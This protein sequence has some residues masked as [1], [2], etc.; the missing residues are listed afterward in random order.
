MH[1]YMHT[2]HKHTYTHAY[3][4]AYIR[5]KRAIHIGRRR[6][7]PHGLRFRLDGRFPIVDGIFRASRQASHHVP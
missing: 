6:A 5:E 4:H 3:V 1:T 7:T 2:L